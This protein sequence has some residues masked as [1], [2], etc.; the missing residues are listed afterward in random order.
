MPSSQLRASSSPSSWRRTVT[1]SWN[2][3]HLAGVLGRGQVEHRVGKLGRVDHLGVVDQR[4]HATRQA[5]PAAVGGGVALGHALDDLVGQG[6]QPAGRVE[7]A[8][9]AGALGDEDVSGRAVALLV[10]E[11]RQV[12]R[13]AVADVDAHARLLREVLEEGSDQVLGPAA[14]DHQP[15]AV[16]R[17]APGRREGGQRD[18]DNRPEHRPSLRHAAQASH[19]TL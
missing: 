1:K 13:V 10:D 8:D 6:A 18:H 17:G 5:D 15:L 9:R 2:E 7:V 16:V 4:A 14:V 12:G 11:E 19:A 3:R